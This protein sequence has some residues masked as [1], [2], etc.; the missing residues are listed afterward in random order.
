MCQVS[1][2]VDIWTIILAISYDLWLNFCC[3]SCHLFQ[4]LNLICFCALLHL[5]RL[6]KH[7]TRRL[8]KKEWWLS[9]LFLRCILNVNLVSAKLGPIIV[10]KTIL[11]RKFLHR[12]VTVT[13]SLNLIWLRWTSK[14]RYG[15]ISRFLLSKDS[16]ANP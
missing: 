9:L 10:H 11:N 7:L 3:R 8:C 15:L 1:L 2:S 6:I 13:A 12:H 4:M 5:V 14:I 16:T